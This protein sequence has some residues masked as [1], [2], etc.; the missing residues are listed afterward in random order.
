PI[1]NQIRLAWETLNYAWDTHVLSFDDEAQQSFFS[2]IGL[3]GGE[4]MSLIVGGLI[5]VFALLG[6]Y[7]GWMRWRTRPGIN[8]IKILYENF[9][10]K[11]ARLGAARNPWEGPL[12]FSA[13]AERLLPNESERIRRIS[14]DYIA[15]RYS[16]EA[17]PL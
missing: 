17:A 11:A 9:C 12:D 16:P 3:A 13:R 15:L 2:A 10:R 4:T 8:R 7:A 14:N 1:F 5:I 6:I